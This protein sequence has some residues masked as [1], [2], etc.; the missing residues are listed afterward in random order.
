MIYLHLVNAFSNF[1]DQEALTAGKD[2]R[3]SPSP[4]TRSNTYYA[5]SLVQIVSRRG[6]DARQETGGC[7]LEVVD[8]HS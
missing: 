5:E 2:V 3:L 4:C 1:L 6:D 7:N 8:D